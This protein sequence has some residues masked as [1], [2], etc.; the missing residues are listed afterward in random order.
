MASGCTLASALGVGTRTIADDDF[1]AR[2]L[3]EPVGE[4]LGGAVV[5]QINRP[6]CFEVH[7]KR[8]VATK[9]ASAARPVC[10]A[11][12]FSKSVAPSARRAYV[13]SAPSNRSAKILREQFG[14]WQNHRRVCTRNR[15]V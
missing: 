9:A 7:Q 8:A 4:Y 12:V 3:S 5:E 1:H 6:M 14:E 13:A 2:V 10:N 11:D 15:T